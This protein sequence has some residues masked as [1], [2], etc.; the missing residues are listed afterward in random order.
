MKIQELDTKRKKNPTQK[1]VRS[2]KAI[3]SV[4]VDLMVSEELDKIAEIED[5]TKS[6]LMR[7]ILESFIKIYNEEA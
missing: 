6:V 7:Y 2:G 5:V 4:Y 3:L 1:S